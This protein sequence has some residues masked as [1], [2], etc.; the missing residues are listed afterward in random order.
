MIKALLFDMDGVIIDSHDAWYQAFNQALQHF[1]NRPISKEEFDDNVW[2]RSTIEDGQYFSVPIK[3]VLEYI[4]S[5]AKIFDQVRCNPFVEE[6]LAELKSKG[7]VLV[8]A[9]N[10]P[11][12]LAIKML[13]QLKL[14][15]YFDHIITSSDVEKDKPDP[16]MILT[17]LERLKLRVDDVLFV[18]DSLTDKKAAKAAHTPFVGYG[19]DGEYRINNL[20]ELLRIIG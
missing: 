19:L 16:E 3:E 8:I 7:I 18:G 1:E 2:A 4:V 12:S 5:Q 6:T 9:T 14:N 17:M 13:N 11:R 10:T 15:H 20:K